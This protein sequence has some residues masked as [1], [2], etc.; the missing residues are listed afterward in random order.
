MP[1]VRAGRDVNQVRGLDRLELVPCSARHDVGIACSQHD[2]RL[3]SDHSFITVVEDQLDRSAHHV[4]ELVA[5]R[6]DLAPV[7]WSTIEMRD[8]PD[9]VAID[10]SGR[11]GRSGHH[12][13][14]PIWRD[15]RYLPLEAGRRRL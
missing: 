13:Y 11:T 12:G 9:R 7:W 6:M 15:V 10:P 8:R 5:V 14:G 3:C 2:P 1:A 4:K